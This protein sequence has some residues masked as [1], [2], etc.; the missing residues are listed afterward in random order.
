MNLQTPTTQE[1]GDNL[2]AQLEAELNQTIPLL[3]KSFMRVLAK[4][5]AGVF[6]LL[7]KY[8]GWVALQ[9]FVGTASIDESEINGVSVSPLKEWGRLVGAGDPNP[10]VQAELSVA[11]VVTS[12][13]GTLP[14]GTQLVGQDNG[15]TYL[16]TAAVSLNAGAVVG[17][18]RASADQSGG[19]GSGAIGNLDPAAIVSFVNPLAGVR[20]EAVVTAVTVTGADAEATAA[21]RQRVL[22]RFQQRPQGGAYADYRTWGMTVPGIANIYPY[23]SS[24]P[25]IVDIYVEASDLT[26]GIPT[27]AQLDAVEAAINYDSAGLATR[28]PAGALLNVAAI[29]RTGFTVEIDGLVVDNTAQVQ[30]DITSAVE[31]YFLG[32]EPFI[33]GLSPL[34]RKDRIT[35]SGVTAIVEDIV[36]AAGGVFDDVIL[37][38]SAT[39]FSLRA[40]GEGEKAK[41]TSVSFV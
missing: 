21:Y 30:A 36:S 4:S 18:V 3:P 15:V 37:E 39:P 27:S 19:D 9:S 23:T 34:P 35:D 7:Y 26:D 16:T 13:G 28:R 25:G 29:T 1:V 22:D 5:L 8:G 20:R 14:A 6:I 2:I 24:T 38:E 40:L 12:Q 17:T 31:E 32:R 10:G 41:A 11:I 33:V